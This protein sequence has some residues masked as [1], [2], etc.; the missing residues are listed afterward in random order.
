MKTDSLIEFNELIQPVRIER[1]FVGGSIQGTIAGFGATEMFPID[2]SL[3]IGGENIPKMSEKLQY[4]RLNV[5]SNLNC[6][7]RIALQLING[8]FP[9]F[10]RNSQLCTFND[11]QQ[12]VC[13]GDSGS[14]LLINNEVVGV[15]SRVILPCARGSPDVF[16]RVSEYAN[17]IN[18]H[19]RRT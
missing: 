19:I 7:A 14:A 17:W 15:A 9:R 18:S 6:N 16:I 5:I 11:S 1:S 3:P 4:I 12:G 8:E 10:V 13:Y 2:P